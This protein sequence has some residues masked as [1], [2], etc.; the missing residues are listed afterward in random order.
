MLHSL[1]DDLHED[2]DTTFLIATLV[3]VY[4]STLQCIPENRTPDIYCHDY[5]KSCVVT[6]TL[7]CK[8]TLTTGKYYWEIWSPF[9]IHCHDP[10]WEVFVREQ[11][12]SATKKKWDWVFARQ[13]YFELPQSVRLLLVCHCLFQRQHLYSM[14][15]YCGI[16]F[17]GLLILCHILVT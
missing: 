17:W 5:L 14:L 15:K 4:H 3:T 6:V 13:L 16:Q 12:V 1:M 8:C 11:S 10:G 7:I 2:G 9:H